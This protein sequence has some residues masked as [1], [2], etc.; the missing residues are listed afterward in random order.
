MKRFMGGDF[1]FTIETGKYLNNFCILT[2]C[3][4][5]VYH[6]RKTSMSYT[7]VIRTKE[8]LECPKILEA[9]K[10]SEKKQNWNLNTSKW[11]LF[12]ARTFGAAFY[13]N[14]KTVKETVNCLREY[15]FNF[16]AFV[17]ESS[18]API[19]LLMRHQLSKICNILTEKQKK[20]I[21]SS[22][23]NRISHK[24]VL[25]N[26]VPVKD[27]FREYLRNTAKDV[28]E[29]RVMQWEGETNPF[30][31]FESETLYPVL[32]ITDL[33]KT[34]KNRQDIIIENCNKAEIL[35]GFN[36]QKE[37]PLRITLF[38]ISS[39]ESVLSVTWNDFFISPCTIERLIQDIR[40]KNVGKYNA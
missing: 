28:P 2:E 29:L 19:V 11:S 21:S 17:C 8:I 14:D 12:I 4:G 39:S 10:E 20:I 15:I 24:N 6:L 32:H 22:Y 36:P 31:A 16:R 1:L 9:L 26:F 5:Y 40:V 30:L 25:F 13:V 34:D 18:S 7:T 27:D 38:Q 33:S 37:I 3:Y 35:R 23:L